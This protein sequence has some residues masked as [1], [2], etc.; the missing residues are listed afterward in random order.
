MLKFLKDD[1]KWVKLSA[2]LNLGKFIYLLKGL[3]VNEKLIKRYLK[4]CDKDIIGLGSENEIVYSC[5]FNFP[6]V[7]SVAGPNKWPDM[8]DT[9]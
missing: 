5:A 1:N 3:E 4:M 6:A 8:V 9:Y 2:Y 7:V